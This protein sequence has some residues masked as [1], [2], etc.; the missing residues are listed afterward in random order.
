VQPC[1]RIARGRKPSL[2]LYRV[3]RVD[4]DTTLWPM[5]DV[6]NL[7]VTLNVLARTFRF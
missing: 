2:L 4:E 5:S 1:D 3:V 6:G 7:R